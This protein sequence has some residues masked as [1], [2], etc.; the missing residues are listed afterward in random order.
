M[1]SCASTVAPVLRPRARSL[2]DR[3]RR[4]SPALSV[5]RRV[6]L[7]SYRPLPRRSG[8]GVV[9]HIIHHKYYVCVA[10]R[11]LRAL[12]TV[13]SS[14]ASRVIYSHRRYGRLRTACRQ[15]NKV[16]LCQLV[17]L[18]R[19]AASAVRC[20]LRVCHSSAAFSRRWD[21]ASGRCGLLCW[22]LLRARRHPRPLSCLVPCL[23]YVP[24]QLSSRTCSALCDC[25]VL[26]YTEA[27]SARALV[28]CAM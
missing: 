25:S 26:G 15:Y 14:G 1:R 21:V 7:F 17:Q 8:V 24:A 28:I 3:E 27:R 18:A 5:V 23:R 16:V 4:A 13:A 9:V 11:R 22:G 2:A 10:F 6:P 20:V 12:G 19:T